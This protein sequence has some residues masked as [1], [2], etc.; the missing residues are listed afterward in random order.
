MPHHELDVTFREG[1]RQRRSVQG[2]W[3]RI[4]WRVETVMDVQLRELGLVKPQ[5]K[6]GEEER[7]AVFSYWKVSHAEDRWDLLRGSQGKGLRPTHGSR[8]KANVSP[9]EGTIW[10]KVKLNQGLFGCFGNEC[11]PWTWTTSS[12]VWTNKYLWWCFT[13][14][15]RTG[16]AS[17]WFFEKAL[18][19]D[20][21][22]SDDEN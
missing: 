12:R 19:E 16:W 8:V 17:P 5:E 13:E 1:Y 6:T 2:R 11:T 18:N 3:A 21:V 10:E 9:L 15:F 7:V 20:P 4:S 14:D 22:I